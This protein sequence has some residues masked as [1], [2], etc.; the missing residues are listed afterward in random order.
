MNHPV[1]SGRRWPVTVTGLAVA[2]AAM[3][4]ML[5]YGGAARQEPLPGLPHPGM[6]TIWAL[7]VARL[8]VQVF[9]VATVG[10]LLAA[11]VLSPRDGAGLSAVGFRRLRAASWTALGWSLSAFATL[12][13]TLSDLLGAP[14]PEV[15]SLTSL[16]TFISSVNVGQ[17]FCLTTLLALVVFVIC[18]ISIR[19]VGATIGFLVALLAVVPPIFTGHAASASDHQLAVSGM[20]LHVIPMTLWAGGLLALLVTSRAQPAHLAIAVRRFSP[21]AT[22][23]LVLVAGSGLVSAKVRLP[24]FHDVLTH[25]YG[26]VTLA[27]VAVLLAIAGVGLW[28]RRAA[29]P[30][31]ERGERRVF[32]RVAWI[33]IL[34]FAAAIGIAVAL[35]R[36]AAPAGKTEGDDLATAMLGFPMP[37]PMTAVELV[38]GWLPDPLLFVTP[39]AAAG[40]YLAGV[41][42]LARRG[43]AWPAYRTVCFLVGCAVVLLATVSGMARYGPVLFSMHMTQHLLLAMVAPIFL[44][45][46]APFTLALRVLRKSPDP[47]WP[48]PRE[49]LLAFLHSRYAKVITHPVVA[50]CLYALSM[51]AVYFTSFFQIALRSHAA[52]LFMTFH[53][54]ASGFLFFWLVLGIDPGPRRR[55]APPLRILLLLISMAL[56]AFLGVAIMQSTSLL[57]PGWFSVLPRD[58]G[59]SPLEDQR[60]AGGIAWSF[61]EIPG[62]FITIM[63]VREWIAADKR[64]QRRL[65]RAA[66]RAETEGIEDAH[67]AYNRMLAQLAEEERRL[68]ENRPASHT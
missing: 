37:P 10:L 21:L 27:K 61:G 38:W 55:L 57:A 32:L 17:S 40:C 59:P 67:I 33:E 7:P 34:L 43:D 22:V 15:L 6:F 62:L 31:L 64:E 58:W 16:V 63:L 45:L 50:L 14:L 13:Y 2:I 42:R 26:H 54:V 1:P 5:W 52:H 53:F 12:C 49:W 9:S 3:A 46:A 51:Y 28:Q 11:L 60:I 41:W 35:A 20:L 44:V 66:E 18:R 4:A 39:L 47:A 23:C 8:G 29:M 48:G 36:S 25:P 68:R 30:A 56:H 19:P 65:D 24:T